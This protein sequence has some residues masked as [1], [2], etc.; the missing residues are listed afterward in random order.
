[1]YL[2]TYAYP[3]T[4]PTRPSVYRRLLS[5]WGLGTYQLPPPPPPGTATATGTATACRQARAVTLRLAG[6]APERRRVSAAELAASLPP[7]VAAVQ[8]TGAALHFVDEWERD[9]WMTCQFQPTE[10]RRA[11]GSRH[12]SPRH[13][14][15]KQRCSVRDTSVASARSVE[16]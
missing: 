9:E 3:S 10:R 13:P 1:M 14:A 6:C 4:S 15:T 5:K 11:A 16:L 2:P 12:Q 8:G 7:R